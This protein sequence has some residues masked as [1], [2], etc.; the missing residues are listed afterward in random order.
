VSKRR[1]QVLSKNN[2]Q[3]L[4]DEG[5]QALATHARKGKGKRNFGKRNTGG[6]STLVQE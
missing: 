4:H 2:L 3:R 1:P 6:G 5:T